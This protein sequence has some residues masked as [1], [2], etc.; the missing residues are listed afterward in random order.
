M[1]NQ[2]KLIILAAVAGLS[3]VGLLILLRRRHQDD[4][5]FG[6]NGGGISEK[7]EDLQEFADLTA[8]QAVASA[9]ETIV[10]V[11]VPQYCVG[12]IIG[13]GGEKIRQLK[14]ETGARWEFLDKKNGPK[15]ISP[16]WV[17]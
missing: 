13:K 5:S 17:V 10:R 14:K 6:G 11:N 8:S 3:A 12:V 4:E 16:A 7:E 9:A 2:Q 15:Y 1:N